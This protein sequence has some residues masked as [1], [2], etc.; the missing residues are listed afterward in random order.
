MY[1]ASEIDYKTTMNNAYRFCVL[2][3]TSELIEQHEAYWLPTDGDNLMSIQV[4]PRFEETSD[5]ITFF[6][7]D[8]YKALYTTAELSEIDNFLTKLKECN[9]SSDSEYMNCTG[10]LFAL[11][12]RSLKYSAYRDLIETAESELE[13]DREDIKIPVENYFKNGEKRYMNGNDYILTGGEPHY[14]VFYNEQYTDFG[15]VGM[16]LSNTASQFENLPENETPTFDED[17]LLFATHTVPYTKSL[18]ECEKFINNLN[19]KIYTP[20]EIITLRNEFNRI[21]ESGNDE[22]YLD[23]KNNCAKLISLLDRQS[24]YEATMKLLRS[25]E[26]LGMPEEILWVECYRPELKDTVVIHAN[27]YKQLYQSDK[28]KTKEKIQ[29]EK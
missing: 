24:E 21:K 2:F 12:E 5:Y 9:Y 26:K 17:G 3:N 28:T 23:D 19:H 4:T 29:K 10:R 1:Y 16:S 6:E 15:T 20:E 22:W 27:E 11:F 14:V 18:R 7:R 25:A 13:I 8:A